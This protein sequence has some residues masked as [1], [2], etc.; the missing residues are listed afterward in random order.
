MALII[1][2]S[3]HLFTF[4][5][6][7]HLKYKW[8]KQKRSSATYG[9]KNVSNTFLKFWLILASAFLSKKVITKKKGKTTYPRIDKI[10][11]IWNS[12]KL[13]ERKSWG[14]IDVLEM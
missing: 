14:D 3:L 10:A 11:D 4:F 5:L 9:V 2:V 12:F 1:W 6:Y 13:N 7:I 8:P